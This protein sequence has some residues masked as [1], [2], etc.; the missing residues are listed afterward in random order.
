MLVLQKVSLSTKKNTLLNSYL[1]GFVV[2]R[3]DRAFQSN[4][5]IT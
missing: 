2:I 1:L 4:A 3:N 5:Y